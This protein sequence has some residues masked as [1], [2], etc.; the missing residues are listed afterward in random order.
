MKVVTLGPSK[1]TVSS[2][3]SFNHWMEIRVIITVCHMVMKEG[4]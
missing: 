4:L 3:V 1:T 2:V